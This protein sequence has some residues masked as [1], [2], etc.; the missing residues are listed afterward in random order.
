MRL[1]NADGHGPIEH[2]DFVLLLEGRCAVTDARL[3]TSMIV[4]ASVQIYAVATLRHP[5]CPEVP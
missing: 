3:Y 5:A 1:A 2:R 4:F